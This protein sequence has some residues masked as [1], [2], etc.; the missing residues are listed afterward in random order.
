MGLT[1]YSSHVPLK[2]KYLNGSSVKIEYH[3]NFLIASTEV[4]VTEKEGGYQDLITWDQLPD[5][6]RDALASTVW[7]LTPMSLYGT[8][9][10]LKDGELTMTLEKAWPFD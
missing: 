6:A 9:M 4:R 10:P 7:D 8:E 1:K 2:E 5:A 3:N